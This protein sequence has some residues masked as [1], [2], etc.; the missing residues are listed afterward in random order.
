VSAMSLLSFMAPKTSSGYMGKPS[1]AGKKVVVGQGPHRYEWISDW[2]KMPSGVS[3]EHCHGGI[4]FGSDGRLYLSTD[5]DNTIMVFD[6]DGKFIKAW[7]KDYNN[8]CHG[9]MIRKEGRQEFLYMTHTRL[10]KVIK[11][12]TDGELVWTR[13]YPKQVEEYKAATDYKPTAMAFA[14][15]GD[16]YVTDG[17][18]KYYVHHYNSQGEYIRS[19]GG[20]GSEAGQLSN[21]HGIW[22]DTR[23]RAMPQIVVADRKNNRLQIFTMDGR[24]IGF[25]TEGLRLPSNL[26]QRGEDLVVADL[27]GRVTILGKDNKL[28]THLGDNLDE[29]GRGTNK[30]LKS[31]FKDGIFIAPHCPRWD[32]SGNLY[33]HE[34]SLAG[35]LIKLKKI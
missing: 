24:H 25:V 33:I 20:P 14:P 5:T 26:D 27:A 7:G 3:F 8:G 17:Y 19:F 22:V 4:V 12:T 34:W 15:N 6:S 11:L 31:E 21:P 10:N 16:F 18:G 29:K 23:K 9:I 2:L 32:K 1:A 35:R 30:L 28:L 13:E